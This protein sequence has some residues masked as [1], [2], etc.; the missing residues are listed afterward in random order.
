MGADGLGVP[1][2][3]ALHP[4]ENKAGVVMSLCHVS[5]G[6]KPVF[7]SKKRGEELKALWERRGQEQEMEGENDERQ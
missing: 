6:I 2:V 3:H 5:A 1:A 7:L 4:S